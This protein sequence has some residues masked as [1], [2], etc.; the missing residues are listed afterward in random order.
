MNIPYLAFFH[1]VV[2][3]RFLFIFGVVGKILRG[4]TQK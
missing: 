1:T 3:S 2:L 4:L